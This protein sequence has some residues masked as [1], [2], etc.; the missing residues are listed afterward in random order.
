[1][2]HQKTAKRVTTIL[3]LFFLLSP[4]SAAETRFFDFPSV[5]NFLVYEMEGSSPDKGLSLSGIIRLNVSSNPAGSTF[6]LDVRVMLSIF[7]GSTSENLDSNLQ[8]DLDTTS[9]SMLATGETIGSFLYWTHRL[10]VGSG[11]EVTHPQATFFGSVTDRF[12]HG[13]G[14]WAVNVE[15]Q[16]D[17]RR[18]RAIYDEDSGILYRASLELDPLI[19]RVLGGN[20]TFDPL[21]SFLWLAETNAYMGEADP[22]YQLGNFLTPQKIA[23]VIAISFAV[24]SVTLLVRYASIKSRTE[25]PEDNLLRGLLLALLLLTIVGLLIFWPA[26]GSRA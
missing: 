7:N 2:T 25:N 21:R 22:F 8:V 11:M 14:Y 1:M 12:L 26:F 15:F 20:A 9:N 5:G 18:L 23:Y 6:T 19:L 3:L 17:D 13:G 24:I 10:T 4:T 16:R